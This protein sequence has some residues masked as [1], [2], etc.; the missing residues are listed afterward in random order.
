MPGW[1]TIEV[2]I[3]VLLPTIGGLVWLI[4]LEGK[5]SI[6]SKRID[7]L[8]KLDSEGHKHLQDR[9]NLLVEK[10]DNISAQ[11]NQLI[12]AQQNPPKQ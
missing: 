10:L 8:E 2:V 7:F 4:R 11:L 3:A 5:I 6:N 1:L 12:G 9:I